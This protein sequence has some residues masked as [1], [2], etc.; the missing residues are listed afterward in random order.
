MS[1]K[2]DVNSPWF[3]YIKSQ[4]SF[5]DLSNTV[6]LPRRICDYLID[7]PQGDY[8]P[9]DDNS[10]PRCRLWKYL[11]YDTPRPLEEQL[12][13]IRK[14]MSVVF[15]PEKPETAPTEKG[16]RLIPQVFIKQSQLDAQT[17]IYVYMGRSVPIEDNM[18]MAIS[19]VFRIWTHYTYEANTKTDEYSRVLAIEQALIEALH[20]V[21]MEGV[22]TFF[23]SKFKHP[24]C[25]SEVMYDG[26]E[27]LGRQLTM[28]LEVATTTNPGFG[29]FVNKPLSESPNIRWG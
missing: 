26:Q 4:E 12:P 20:G 24:D 13:S 18:K 10:Y 17:R 6:T 9:K 27:N 11:F 1:Y 7:A 29:E 28:A 16:Y 14:K 19:V 21:N 2:A 23:F 22:G 15:N 25:G 8:E 5:F 3:P